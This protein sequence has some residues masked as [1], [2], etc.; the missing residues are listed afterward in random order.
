MV[1]VGR[2]DPTAALGAL[3]ARKGRPDPEAV[4]VLQ[5]LADLASVAMANVRLYLALTEQKGV[6]EE[7]SRAKSEFLANMSHEI[8]TP[9]N[10]IIGMTDLGLMNCADP[11]AAKYLQL[12]K[13]SGLALLDIINDIL[14]LSK[15]EAGQLELV[16]APFD[17]R[18]TL[19]G[20]VSALGVVARGKDIEL[21]YAIDP[22]APSLVLG[23]EGRLRQ[24]LN[25]LIGNAIKFTGHGRVDIDMAVT[26]RDEAERRAWVRYTVRDTGIGIPADKL[27]AI[28]ES[29]AQVGGSAHAK[30]GG[31]GL[32]LSIAR[33]LVERMGGSIRVESEVGKGSTFSVTLPFE[34][35]EARPEQAPAGR[36]RPPGTG[37]KL[38]ILL[39][40]DNQVNRML[41]TELLRGQGHTVET[42]E[43]GREALARLAAQRF[44]LV[45]MDVRMPGLDGIEATEAIRR[46]E[47]G[48]PAIPIIALTAHALKGDRERFLAAGMSDYVSKPINLE[49]LNT[50]M[51][52]VAG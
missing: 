10:G 36:D 27:G 43:D 41:A 1:P 4:Q 28:F 48:D 2:D 44:D 34:L 6:A 8:R 19:H 9:L 7:A 11:K 29:F 31:T 30:Y 39:A 42:A 49:E 33:E 15:I 35:A 12:T 24:I 20:L 17:P 40:E 23:D 37:R 47:A 38:R 45:L 22:S 52:R 21:G 50:V 32:G 16:Q 18:Q 25:N 5:S 51:A 13:Q 46:G 26:G 3:W 14:D